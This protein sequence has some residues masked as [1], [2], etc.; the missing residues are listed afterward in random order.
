MSIYHGNNVHAYTRQIHS[1]LPHY[2]QKLVK[3]KLELTEWEGL[4]AQLHHHYG[5]HKAIMNMR[6]VFR[7]GFIQDPQL[8][9]LN[10]AVMLLELWKLIK[11]SEDG[12]KHFKETLDWI[13]GTCIQGVTHRVFIDYVAISQDMLMENLVPKIGRLG[14]FLVTEFNVK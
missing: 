7:N 10:T 11:G 12:R 5:N 9:G 8:P 6:R 13:G 14:A 3:E 4:V 1:L 2:L